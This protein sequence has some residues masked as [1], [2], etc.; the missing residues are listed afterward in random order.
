MLAACVASP[1][2]DIYQWE[3]GASTE[4]NAEQEKKRA[5]VICLGGTGVSATPY[6]NLA[7]RDLTLGYLGNA[8]IQNTS[9]VSTTLTQAHLGD[10]NLTDADFTGAIIAE[11][12]FSR[13]NLS[14]DQ[15]VST[16]SYQIKDLHGI[17]L[18]Y[19]DLTGIN[20]ADQNL[21]GVR[22]GRSILPSPANSN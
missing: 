14:I 2:A 16:A 15:F 18:A 3:P 8:D 20:L 6:S 21:T 19:Y 12:D 4:T 13:S 22:L 1:R 5:S 9:L 10:A 7:S 11:A 17:N